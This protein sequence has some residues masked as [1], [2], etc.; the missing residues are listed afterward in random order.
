ML[1]LCFSLG[2]MLY[3]AFFFVCV[4]KKKAGRIFPLVYVAIAT[5]MFC[6]TSLGK[7]SYFKYFLIFFAIFT[8]AFIIYNLIKKK[9]NIGEIVKLYIRPSLLVFV[10]FFIYLYF[11]LGNVELSN[12]DDLNFWGI[13]VLDVLRNDEFYTLDKY[14]VLGNTTYPPFSTLLE[15][16]FIKMFGSVDQSFSMLAMGTFSFSFFLALFDSYEFSFQGGFKTILTFVIT[17]FITLSV[18]KNYSMAYD[19]YIYNSLYVDWI[20]AI[21]LG[22]GISRLVKFD[23]YDTYSYFEIGMCS[24]ILIATKQIGM[25]LVLLITVMTGLVILLKLNLKKEKKT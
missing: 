22:F 15:A 18:Q 12:I 5:L 7:L 13:R 17:V 6:A 21:V 8:M 19:S 20:L 25:A 1:R 14:A 2:V 4:T 23:I 3:L 10:L 24:Y 9:I 11:V 16:A